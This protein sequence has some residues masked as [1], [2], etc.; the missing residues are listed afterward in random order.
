MMDGKGFD[1]EGAILVMIIIAS[2]MFE[3]QMKKHLKRR[4]KYV[5]RPR[6]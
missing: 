2:L 6:W 3:H 4:M 5:P 1:W